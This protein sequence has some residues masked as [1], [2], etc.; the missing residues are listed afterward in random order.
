M[1]KK[2]KKSAGGSNTVVSEKEMCKGGPAWR[3]PPKVGG[4]MRGVVDH[5][6]VASRPLGAK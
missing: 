6:A 3:Q 1:D 4:Q 5:A 2:I